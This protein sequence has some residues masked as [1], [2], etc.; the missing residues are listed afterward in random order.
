MQ[1]WKL[2][3]SAVLAVSGL[4][5][6]Y[7]ESD[8]DFV[9]TMKLGSAEMKAKAPG[10]VNAEIGLT[11]MGVT[12]LNE[13]QGYIEFTGWLEMKWSD[14]RFKRPDAEN[15]E[16]ASFNVNA[17]DIWTPDIEL[18]NVASTGYKI[19]NRDR[20]AVILPSD[21]QVLLY[22]LFSARSLCD[23]RGALTQ[24]DTVN[25]PI[26]FGLWTYNGL[27]VNLFLSSYPEDSESAGAVHDLPLSEFNATGKWTVTAA[28]QQR[29]V[30]LYPCCPEPYPSVTFTL[31]LRE[32]SRENSR[33]WR[34]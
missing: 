1:H 32:R 15:T 21:G 5:L 10:V 30:V 28:T 18:Y 2:I 29:Q 4:A 23:I 33:W 3:I 16:P 6:S 9:T 27:Q 25:C 20:K 17:N 11:L 19:L 12:E 7:P 13:E 26:K 8:S 34:L 22:D 14:S 31:S 24:G